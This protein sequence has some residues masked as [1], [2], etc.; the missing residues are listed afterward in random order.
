MGKGHPEAGGRQCRGLDR[1]GY[2]HGQLGP[3]PSGEPWEPVQDM[4]LVTLRSRLFPLGG[5]GD[6]VFIQQRGAAAS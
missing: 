1:V 3:G 6:G 5:E 4:P 2:P